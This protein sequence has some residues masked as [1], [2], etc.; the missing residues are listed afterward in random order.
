MNNEPLFPMLEELQLEGLPKLGHFLLTKCL[1]DV[2]IDDCP[3]IKTFIQQG[4]SVST[5][6]L[7]WVNYDDRVEVNDLNEWIQHRFN[8]KVF[9]APLIVQLIKSS[10]L[11][12]SQLYIN[13]NIQILI[14]VCQLNQL[15]CTIFQLKTLLFSA[16]RNQMPVK[17]LPKVTNL[18]LMMVTNLK[19]L[20]TQKGE[21]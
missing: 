1:R 16:P 13:S 3:E 12:L 8:S 20:M 14:Y 17:A 21:P 2:K 19:L 7:A 6:G 5:A 15:P 4:V 10:A 9:L 11:F 18:K